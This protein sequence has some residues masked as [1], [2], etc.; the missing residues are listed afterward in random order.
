MWTIRRSADVMR[1]AALFG[2]VIVI[3]FACG[4]DS[5]G[6]GNR[7]RSGPTVSAVRHPT[8]EDFPLPNGFA[9]VNDHSSSRASGVTRWVE[10]GRLDLADRATP[11]RRQVRDAVHQRSRG[12]RRQRRSLARQDRGEHRNPSA[13]AG[14]RG[15]ASA[16]G[17]TAMKEWLSPPVRAVIGALPLG[18]Q[19]M[20]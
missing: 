20:G 18:E 4:C 17:A 11:P 12:M 5:F 3:A 16:A 1:G 15:P 7:V 8:I 10:Y 13:A 14:F 2:G 19:W 9:L 6:G